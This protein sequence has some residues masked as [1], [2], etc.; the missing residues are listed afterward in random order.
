MGR[1][2]Y[3]YDSS[4][5]C[6]VAVIDNSAPEIVPFIL[7][8]QNWIILLIIICILYWICR[9]N[10]NTDSP[11]KSDPTKETTPLHDPVV[12]REIEKGHI[13]HNKRSTWKVTENPLYEPQ[14][15]PKLDLS[16]LKAESSTT[17]SAKSE[18]NKNFYEKHDIS[19]SDIQF[20]T[21]QTDTSMVNADPSSAQASHMLEASEQSGVSTPTLK[22]SPQGSEINTMT[23]VSHVQTFYTAKTSE[24]YITAKTHLDS[25]NLS[26]VSENTPTKNEIEVLDKIEK[27][28]A[29]M[30][31]SSDDGIIQLPN[32]TS[33]QAENFEGYLSVRKV[34]SVKENK[35]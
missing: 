35:E 2:C 31:E 33:I 15:S 34:N 22:C 18:I 9:Q 27:E 6:L 11:N 24:T 28:M 8:P 3:E 26:E 14:P 30:E 32:L 20:A 16:N 25:Q 5:Q 23:T 17:E 21:I 7:Q 13:I 29:K 12:Q 10:K 19:S 1:T 4:G